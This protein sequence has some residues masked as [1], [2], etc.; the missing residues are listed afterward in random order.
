M[1]VGY[2]YGSNENYDE[3]DGFS[4]PQIENKTKKNALFFPIR[5]PRLSQDWLSDLANCSR[6]SQL[7]V[8]HSVFTIRSSW[9]EGHAPFDSSKAT[10]S[11]M[12]YLTSRRFTKTIF[13]LALP[14]ITTYFYLIR[15]N[16]VILQVLEHRWLRKK[17]LLFP[18]RRAHTHAHIRI[19]IMLKSTYRLRHKR[20]KRQCQDL[21]P[22]IL[23][24]LLFSLHTW[25]HS[26]Y[27]YNT[28][29]ILFVFIQ[30]LC[31]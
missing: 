1:Y 25:T 11:R 31:N 27:T 29:G 16:Y 23:C 10:L 18:T 12:M 4:M 22:F 8:L 21:F 19:H 17:K 28:N 3:N 26:R 6:N 5:L 7:T 2:K 20:H 13:G 30:D 15:I 24:I 9:Y 14:P